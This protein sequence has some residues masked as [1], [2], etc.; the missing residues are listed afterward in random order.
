MLGASIRMLDFGKQESQ[1]N[2]DADA[3]VFNAIY[4]CSIM[5]GYSRCQCVI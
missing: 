2:G 5:L 4:R 3:A 1:C